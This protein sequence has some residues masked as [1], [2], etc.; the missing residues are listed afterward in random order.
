MNYQRIYDAMILKAQT[1]LDLAGYVETHHILP[2]CMGGT[3]EHSNLVKLTAREHFIAHWLLVKMHPTVWKLYY[4]MFQ[5]T[6]SNGVGHD[7]IVTSRQFEIARRAISIGAKMRFELGLHPRITEVGR[8]VL[9][10]KMI[11][12]L[13]PMRLY[14]ERNQTARPHRVLFDDGSER[15]YQYGKLGYEDIG[16]SRSSWITAVRKGIPVPTFKVKQIIKE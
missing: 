6:K 1:R 13:N 9:S 7:R 12:D 5:M 15:V 10:A 3:N 16:M 2:K 8:K 14:P 11:G 4:A